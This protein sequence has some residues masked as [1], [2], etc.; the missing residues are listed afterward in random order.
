[1]LEIRISQMSHKMKTTEAGK[2]LIAEIREQIADEAHA[3]AP[4][5]S[6]ALRVLDGKL[7]STAEAIY[8]THRSHYVRAH[9]KF[10]ILLQCC[11]V[12]SNP[13]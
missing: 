7:Q 9:S 13:K 4:L 12:C 8:L 11:S 10:W 2:S 6:S 5:T 1:M 3:T